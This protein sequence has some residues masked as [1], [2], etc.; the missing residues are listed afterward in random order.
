M[1]RGGARPGAWLIAVGLTAM[2]AHYCLSRALRLAEVN[3]VLPMD[4]MRL[5]LV[6]LLGHVLYA[7]PIDAFAVA[8]TALIVLANVANARALARGGA[9]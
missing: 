4:F 3:V 6:A 8:G 5:P 7:E 2:S 9:R 1:A